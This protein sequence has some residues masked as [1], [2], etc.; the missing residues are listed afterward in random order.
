M[1][2]RGGRRGSDHGR[3]GVA[4]GTSDGHAGATVARVGPIGVGER[5]AVHAIWQSISGEGAGPAVQVAA[6]ESGLAR[7][8][9]AR[10]E[11]RTAGEGGE[12]EEE[13]GRSY[14]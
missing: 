12:E 1:V 4:P 13:C 14:S 5:G 9:R 7:G 3:D 2:K 11:H 10:L 8:G 6:V